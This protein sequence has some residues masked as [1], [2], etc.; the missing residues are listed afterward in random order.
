MSAPAKD[1]LLLAELTIFVEGLVVYGPEVVSLSSRGALPADPEKMKAAGLDPAPP[2]II[3]LANNIDTDY[4]HYINYYEYLSNLDYSHLSSEVSEFCPQVSIKDDIPNNS[5]AALLCNAFVYHL[6]RLAEEH[7]KPWQKV[8]GKK[9]KG[10]IPRDNHHLYAAKH[11]RNVLLSSRLITE[12]E[13]D[14]AGLHHAL[15]NIH[16]TLPSVTFWSRAPV[17]RPRPADDPSHHVDVEIFADDMADAAIPGA[18]PVPALAP[19]PEPDHVKSSFIPDYDPLEGR[20][21]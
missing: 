5:D 7:L 18:P 11:H 16:D 13:N 15:R 12:P 14:W 21:H 10:V 17:P 4:Y 19:A 9:W 3:S 6:M 1:L 20:A 2:T 8:L